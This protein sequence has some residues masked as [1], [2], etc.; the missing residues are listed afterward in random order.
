MI[1]LELAELQ[2]LDLN[3]S[4]NVSPEIAL[5]ARHYKKQKASVSLVSQ[6]MVHDCVGDSPGIL[7]PF[8]ETVTNS[9]C[10]CLP[11]SA[12]HEWWCSVGLAWTWRS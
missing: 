1:L 6:F 11:L 10:G 4:G 12:P 5:A 7:R 9:K 8:S 2:Q 3:L